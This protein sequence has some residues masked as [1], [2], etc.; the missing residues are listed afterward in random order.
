VTNKHG[1]LP[2]GVQPAGFLKHPGIKASLMLLQW[3][4][5]EGLLLKKEQKSDQNKN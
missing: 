5:R 1:E 4:M 2:S 3:R